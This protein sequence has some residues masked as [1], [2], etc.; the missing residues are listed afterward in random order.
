MWC[1]LFLHL[2]LTQGFNARAFLLCRALRM[3]ER[4]SILKPINSILFCHAFPC[5]FA[6]LFTGSAAC[7]A[8]LD[9]VGCEFVFEWSLICI[10]VPE[11]A[12]GCPV[13]ARTSRLLCSVV[14]APG[15]KARRSR[16]DQAMSR[17]RDSRGER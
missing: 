14:R 10:G 15:R 8:L 5:C 2:F 3:K 6:E 16:D 9:M 4:S 11:P 13:L 12:S 1:R 7:T 17:G